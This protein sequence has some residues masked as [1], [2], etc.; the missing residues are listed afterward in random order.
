MSALVALWLAFF[1]PE[2]TT[3]HRVA[4]TVAGVVYDAPPMK[5]LAIAEHESNLRADVVTREPGDRVSCGPMTPT[6]QRACRRIELTLV[7][8]YL[9]GARHWTTWRSICS[10][11]FRTTTGLEWCADLA[12][13]GGL[14]LVRACARGTRVAGGRGDA[15]D[16]H[17]DLVAR[18]R[19][20]AESERP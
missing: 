15:C 5:L 16:V 9:A 19:R 18:A 14:A 10:A 8:G 3:D 6:P 20:L 2:T 7:G 12:Y 1:G 13:A 11:R 4:A 17:Q